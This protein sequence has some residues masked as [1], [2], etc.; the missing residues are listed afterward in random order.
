MTGSATPPPELEPLV[1]ESPAARALYG[2]WSGAVVTNVGAFDLEERLKVVA[3]VAAQLAHRTDLIVEIV[4]EERWHARITALV[5]EQIGSDN[6]GTDEPTTRKRFVV[7]RKICPDGW[8]DLP[9]TVRI[10]LEPYP[11]A[12]LPAALTRV[13]EVVVAGEPRPCSVTGNA[14]DLEWFKEYVPTMPFDVVVAGAPS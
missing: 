11:T 10:S 14:G 8:G 12:A 9:G 5:T 1:V 6:V 7:L 3:D 13:Q 2:V 4:A